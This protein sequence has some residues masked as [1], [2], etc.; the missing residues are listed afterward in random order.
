MRRKFVSAFRQSRVCPRPFVV[1]L[2][3]LRHLASTPS[4][5]NSGGG[6]S[7]AKEMEAKGFVHATP[8]F[9][10]STLTDA[11]QATTAEVPADLVTANAENVVLARDMYGPWLVMTEDLQGEL[12]VDHDAFVFYRPANGLGY[13]VGTLEVLD[14]KKAGTAFV[15]KL[16]TYAYTQSASFAP[17]CGV[18]IEVTGM[19]KEVSSASTQYRTLSLIGILAKD[20]PNRGLSSDGKP[21][22]ADDPP[23]EDLITG[24]FNAAKLSPWTPSEKDLPW[25]PNEALQQVFRE[26]FPQE[27]RLTSHVDRRNQR[28]QEDPEGRPDKS[29]SSRPKVYHMDLEKYR[30]GAIP[31]VYYVPDYINEDEE[32][33]ILSMVRNTPADL[34][35]ELKKRTVQEWGCTMCAECEKSFVS[36]TNMPPWVQQCSDMLMY[37]GIFTPSTFLNSVRIHEY[38]RGEGIG[39]HCDGPIYVPCV[40]VLSLASTSVMHFYPHQQPYLDRPMDHYNDTFKFSEGKIGAQVPLMTVVMEPRSLLVFADTAYYYYPHGVSDKEVDDLSPSTAGE[41]VNRH[42]L[43]DKAI[44]SVERRY[45]VSITTRNLLTRCNHQPARAEY[46]MKRSWYL[47]HQLPVPQPLFTL[48]PGMEVPPPSAAT[49]TDGPST[50][51]TAPPTSLSSSQL[52]TWEQR[53]D[54]VF[55]QQEEIKRSLQALKELLTLSASAEAQFRQDVSAVLNHLTTTVLD[56]S[57][58]VEDL[59]EA[60]EE[61]EGK[62]ACATPSAET[63]NDSPSPPNSATQDERP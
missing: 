35:S 37:D 33:Q 21:V 44:M 46:S 63:P 13:G 43:R 56:V 15:L 36:D 2:C 23:R 7:L 20:D 34:K 61:K 19:V 31:H 55:A 27:L 9:S 59:H 51:T 4:P 54:R 28:A 39:P 50:A 38:K 17:R 41:V 24:Q 48:P 16:E 10:A 45:R 18:T 49:E 8:H 32:S 47:F 60:I 58:K 40:T 3:S 11:A 14:A 30:V 6:G 5:S 26:V 52:F 25:Q 29:D 22:S 62:A 1:S 42:L 53:M 12:F 57:A